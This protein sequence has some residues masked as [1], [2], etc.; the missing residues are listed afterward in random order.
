MWMIESE[1]TCSR[2]VP[3]FM[4]KIA[5]SVCCWIPTTGFIGVHCAVADEARLNPKRTARKERGNEFLTRILRRPRGNQVLGRE[6]AVRLRSDSSAAKISPQ[7][8]THASRPASRCTESIPTPAT[9]SRQLTVSLR[10]GDCQ[11]Q[12]G[13]KRG[14]CDIVTHLFTVYCR[15]HSGFNLLPD[16]PCAS[17]KSR[18]GVKRA[19]AS[20]N[21]ND[22]VVSGRSR[23]MV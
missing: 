3:D 20:G 16:R 2:R 9:A 22:Y 12:K 8:Q 17:E 14:A 10:C 1:H 23:L 15:H 13:V 4:V 19:L 5:P 7:R 11:R 21:E 18:C 6:L